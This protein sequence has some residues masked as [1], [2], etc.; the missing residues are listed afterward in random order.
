MNATYPST[1]T[2]LNKVADVNQLAMCTKYQTTRFALSKSK[3]SAQDLL[4]KKEVSKIRCNFI[5]LD[6]I[7]HSDAMTSKLISVS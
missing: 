2:L 5:F 1:P 7:P 3:F 6:D 4:V